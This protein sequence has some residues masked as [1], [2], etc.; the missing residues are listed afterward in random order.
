[1]WP[2]PITMSLR[3]RRRGSSFAA[4]AESSRN[5]RCATFFAS[6]TVGV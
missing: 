5:D 4:V 1:M 2:T 6:V 3:F